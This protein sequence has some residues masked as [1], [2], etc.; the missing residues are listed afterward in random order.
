MAAVKVGST[1]ELMVVPLVF[2]WVVPKVLRKVV[3]R[4][5]R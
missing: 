4:V 5:A 1:A 2:Y 3:R